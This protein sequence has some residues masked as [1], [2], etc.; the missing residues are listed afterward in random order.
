MWMV[1]EHF[2]PGCARGVVGERKPL[3]GTVI[4]CLITVHENEG[5]LMSPCTEHYGKHIRV[6]CCPVSSST[7]S[8]PVPIPCRCSAANADPVVIDEGFTS[9]KKQPLYDEHHCPLKGKGVVFLPLLL[10][11]RVLQS[12]AKAVAELLF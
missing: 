12:P 5:E 3:C 7:T 8:A 11:P 9:L 6:R 2:A 4:T 1:K 10:L